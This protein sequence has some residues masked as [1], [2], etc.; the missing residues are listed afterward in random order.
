MGTAG[1]DKPFLSMAR[2]PKL[3]QHFL[4]DERYRGRIV[5]ALPLLRE[6]LVVEIGPGRGAMTGLLAARV[7][8]LVAIEIDPSLAGGLRQ[9]WRQDGH[10][11]VV[12][13]DILTSDLAQLCRERGFQSCFIFGNVPY[14]IT[15]PIVHHLFRFRSVVHGMAI[16]VQREVAER[17]TATPGTREYGYLSVL[18]QLYSRPHLGFRVPAGAFSPSP[19]VDSA[20]VTFEMTTH[21]NATGKAGPGLVSGLRP[22]AESDFL[23]FVKACFSQKRKSVLNNLSGRYPRTRVEGALKGMVLDSRTRAEQLGVQHL[24]QLYE[25]VR[26]RAPIEHYEI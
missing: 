26:A 23:E 13:G 15:S 22:E 12:N 17:L 16:V 6:D 9:Q 10:V 11:E 3:G 18:T 7:A 25:R 5:D 1:S 4:V 19:K 20:L 8:R 21:L 24:V 14:Y 2:L